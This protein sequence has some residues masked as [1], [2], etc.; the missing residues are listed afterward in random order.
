MPT[1]AKLDR[2]A[3]LKEKLERCSIAVTTSYSGL[4]VN[5]MTDL[6][7][8]LRDSGVELIVIKNTLINLA[9][10]EAQQPQLKEIVQGPT[11]VAFGYDD[12]ADVARA[13][14]DYIRTARSSLVIQ[15]AVLGGGASLPAGEV[16][17]LATLP[18]KPQ[19]VSNLMGQMQAPLQRLLG[20]LNGPLRSLDGLLQARIQ[21]LESAEASS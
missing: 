9:A 6:R 15:G 19:L 2:V 13:L 14:S 8:R 18:S 20:V 4:P 10:D 12:P 5:E 17:R 3:E 7:R 16:N 21:Q 1:P 11:A